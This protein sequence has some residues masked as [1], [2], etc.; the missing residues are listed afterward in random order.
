VASVDVEV[1]AELLENGT[2]AALKEAARLQ[3]E[4]GDLKVERAVLQKRSAKQL[5]ELRALVQPPQMPGRRAAAEPAD[6]LARAKSEEVFKADLT[7][8]GSAPS[9]ATP[10]PPAV[11]AAAKALEQLAVHDISSDGKEG[12]VEGMFRARVDTD[13]ETVGGPRH[14]AGEGGPSMHAE[15]DDTNT[16]KSDYPSDPSMLYVQRVAELEQHNDGLQQ[17]LGKLHQAESALHAENKE[18]NDLIAHLMQRA[19][20]KGDMWGANMQRQER[21]FWRRE[22]RGG[23]LRELQ[24]TIEET[25]SDNIRLRNE[26]QVMAERFR[27][28]LAETWINFN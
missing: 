20:L 11:V 23:G 5:Q 4:I 16:A 19:N 15:E 28:E 24:L 10:K 21:G 2:V 1:Q 27:T 9:T 26:I 3:T 7:V 8:G 17:Q 22:L 6:R 14:V 18:K 25:Q 12:V 13:P